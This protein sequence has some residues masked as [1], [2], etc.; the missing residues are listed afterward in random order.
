MEKDLLKEYG[1][2]VTMASQ[3]VYTFRNAPGHLKENKEFIAQLCK[4]NPQILQFASLTIR[5]DKEF[6]LPL[7][8]F[9]GNLLGSLSNK[10]RA[11]KEV[12]KAAI[13]YSSYYMLDD[14]DKTLRQDK[15]FLLELIE[16]APR[17]MEYSLGEAR[18]DIFLWA[19]A[20]KNELKNNPKSNFYEQF[21]LFIENYF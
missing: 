7:M 6:C 21:P 8:V 13:Y 16:K 17:V 19:K 1:E 10:L 20:L 12:V 15:S 3:S 4:I 5:D 14:A 2:I 18:E 9:A 11:D